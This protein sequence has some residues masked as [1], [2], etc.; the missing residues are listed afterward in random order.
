MRCAETS[1]ETSAESQWKEVTMIIKKEIIKIYVCFIGMILL[2]GLILF[3]IYVSYDES[4]ESP[5]IE[6]KAVEPESQSQ[7]Q[8]VS[9]LPRPSYMSHILAFFIG[10]LMSRHFR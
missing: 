7:Q 1:M 3:A 5:Q 2:V 4:P 8:I 10:F 9:D 6:I